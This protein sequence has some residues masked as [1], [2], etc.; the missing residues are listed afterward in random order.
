M[1][2]LFQ[3]RG[4][5]QEVYEEISGCS[6]EII[7][8]I[9]DGMEMGSNNAEETETQVVSGQSEVTREQQDVNSGNEDEALREAN[10]YVCSEML[11]C[12]WSVDPTVNNINNNNRVSVLIKISNNFISP[13]YNVYS[14]TMYFCIEKS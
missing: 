12:S 13:F 14:S 5:M 10:N 1:I 8:P 2:H 4:E 11:E 7:Y 9:L 6:E 3:V